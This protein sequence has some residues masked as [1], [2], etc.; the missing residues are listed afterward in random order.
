MIVLSPAADISSC[1][2]I[3][4]T[5]LPIVLPVAA[6]AFEYAPREV[7]EAPAEGTTAFLP[8]GRPPAAR[9]AWPTGPE[10]IVWNQS[11]RIGTG[12]VEV[13]FAPATGPNL[14]NLHQA[15]HF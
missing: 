13:I 10:S 3:N 9:L 7:W 11:E 15:C 2:E 12:S 14:L 5:P 1:A 4:E 8:S 6:F